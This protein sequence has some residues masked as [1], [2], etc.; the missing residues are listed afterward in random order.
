MGRGDTIKKLKYLL[1]LLLPESRVMKNAY[2]RAILIITPVF[3]LITVGELY[4]VY[5]AN[6]EKQINKFDPE[7]GWV[8]KSNFTFR[9]VLSDITGHSYNAVVTTNEHGFREW[10]DIHADKVK[11]LFIGDSFT[12]GIRMSDKDAYFSQVKKLVNA[13]VFAIGGG[14][15]GTLQEL[16]LLRKYAP[17]INPD[18][19]VLQFC[20]NDFFNNSISLE[21]RSIVRNQKNLRPYYSAGKITYRHAGNQWYKF[22][23]T[24]SHIFRFLDIKFQRIQFYAYDGYYPPPSDAD[25][26]MIDEEMIKAEQTTEHLLKMMADSVPPKTTLLT[27]ICSTKDQTKTERWIRVAKEAGFMPLPQAS[28]AVEKA[29]KEGVIV[30]DADG[31]HWGLQGHHIAGKVLARE[32]NNYIENQ[33]TP[34]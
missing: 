30:R 24:H 4:G 13:E 26:I 18:Y 32:L 14:G 27:F 31:G 8:P 7:L 22:L 20:H 15:Y 9:G 6:T 17:I 5:F 28:R 1:R 10:G 33:V 11:I 19:F 3:V 2:F 21:G 16:M 29:E 25:K 23:Y 12:G 34:R